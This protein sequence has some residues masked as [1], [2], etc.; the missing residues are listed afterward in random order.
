MIVLLEDAEGIHDADTAEER[1]ERSDD[2]EARDYAVTLVSR[3]P[4]H[5]G[6][7]AT[8]VHSDLATSTWFSP[9]E[10]VTGIL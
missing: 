8:H 1:T 3:Y 7:N 4:K 6:Q 5:I 9:S 10:V 2:G